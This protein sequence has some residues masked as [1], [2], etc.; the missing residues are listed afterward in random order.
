MSYSFKIE[1]PEFNPSGKDVKIDELINIDKYV[2][3]VN[4]IE[5]KKEKKLI[6]EEQYKFLVLGATRF[7]QFNYANIDEYYCKADK[8]MQEMIEKEMLV[9]IDVNNKFAESYLN[10]KKYFQPFIEKIKNENKDFDSNSLDEI[11]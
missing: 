2:E 5:I 10:L 6:N 4:E 9:L 3:I 8:D 11:F 7:L 1:I